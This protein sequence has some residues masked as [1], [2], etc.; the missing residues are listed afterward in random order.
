MSRSRQVILEPQTAEEIGVS[1]STLRAWRQKGI[2][3]RF[4]RF[5]RCVRY[6][7]RDLDEFVRAHAVGQKGTR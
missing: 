3:P 7:R 4:H 5:G 1:V 6:F 2:G